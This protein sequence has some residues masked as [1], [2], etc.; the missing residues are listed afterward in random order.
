[1]VFA[2]AGTRSR[3]PIARRCGQDKRQRSRGGGDEHNARIAA[4]NRSLNGAT[5]ETIRH[6]AVAAEPGM[7]F[8]GEELN[9]RASRGRICQTETDAI[10]IDQLT[11]S[12]GPP[13]ATSPAEPSRSIP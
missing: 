3:G 9:A 1:M 10:T 12:H 13:D 11:A 4:I 7:L 2:L 6:A 8:V 5:Q